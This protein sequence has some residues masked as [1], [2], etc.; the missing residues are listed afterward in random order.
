MADRIRG[1]G[2]MRLR[3][4]G[5]FLALLMTVAYF[6]LPLEEVGPHRPV[7]SWTL[8]T[9]ALTLVA[10]LL[11]FQVRDVNTDRPGTRPGIAIPLLM[12]LSLLV[13]SGAY[14]AL[15]RDPGQFVGLRT[16]LDALYFTI[17]TLATVSYGD[18]TPQGQ[19]ARTVTLVQIFYNFVF[20]TAG[21]TALSRSLRTRLTSGRGRDGGAGKDDGDGDSDGDGDGNGGSDSRGGDVSGRRDDGR[22]D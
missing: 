14:H 19:T 5:G 9:L 4:L 13:F 2:P 22:H 15:A 17:G 12:C 21:A 8:V 11:L 16:R 1:A 3:L 6:L 18:V 10:L 7:I 20:L